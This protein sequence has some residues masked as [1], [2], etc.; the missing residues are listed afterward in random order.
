MMISSHC[1][2]RARR[3]RAPAAVLPTSPCCDPEVSVM[4][5]LSTMVATI[6]LLGGSW[7]ATAADDLFC[8]GFVEAVGPK[9]RGAEAAFI[10]SYEPSAGEEVLPLGLSTTAFVY[11]NAL[12]AI[13]LA[14]CDHVAEARV[15]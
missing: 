8:T 12:A 13:A 7:P 10:R 5:W 11:D 2:R 6:A 14:A 3:P 4:R 9:L 1:R 15:I